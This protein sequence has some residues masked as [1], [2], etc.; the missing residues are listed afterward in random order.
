MVEDEV[1]IAGAVSLG[2]RQ[3]GYTDVASDG[4]DGLAQARGPLRANLAGRYAVQNGRIGCLRDVG[5]PTPIQLLTTRDLIGDRVR[6][7]ESARAG[8]GC[9]RLSAQAVRL[10]RATCLYPLPARPIS[11]SQLRKS[12][13]P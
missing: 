10:L 1:P 7:L 11:P 12:L 8:N 3:A 5:N 13:N 2:L 6:G 4:L 9:G